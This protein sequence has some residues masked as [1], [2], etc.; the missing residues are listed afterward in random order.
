M[1][2]LLKFEKPIGCVPCTMVQNFLNE[3]GIA[4]DRINPFENPE[5][6]GNFNIGSVPTLILLDEDGNEVMRSVGYVQEDLDQL[7]SILKS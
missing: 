7:H 5:L 6:A 3:K 1:K 4:A 2:R